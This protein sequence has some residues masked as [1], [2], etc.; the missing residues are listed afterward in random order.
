M[1][2]LFNDLMTKQPAGVCRLSD[3][4]WIPLDPENRDYAEY[5]A[6]V[7]AGNTPRPVDG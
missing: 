4:A 6:W 2:K 5:L 3:M 1:Y 7:T